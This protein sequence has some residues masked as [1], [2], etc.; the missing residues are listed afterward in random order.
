M[1]QDTR[2]DLRERV[3]RL[4]RENGAERT[5]RDLGISKLSVVT[6]AGDFPQ[7]RPMTEF[8]ERQV[9]ALSE[10]KAA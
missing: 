4:I 3:G 10:G 8:I 1:P 7:S 2:K 5:A 9:L 6:Y